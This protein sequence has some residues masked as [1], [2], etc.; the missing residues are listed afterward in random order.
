[1]QQNSFQK[2]GMLNINNQVNNQIPNNGNFGWRS[3][4]DIK[5]DMLAAKTKKN[6]NTNDNNKNNSQSVDNSLK[7]INHI[8]RVENMKNFNRW[9]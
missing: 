2:N 3:I 5:D 8:Q 6:V 4:Q 1:M 7:N 9:K